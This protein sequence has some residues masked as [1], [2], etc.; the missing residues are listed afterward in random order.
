MRKL[1]DAATALVAF[2][3]ALLALA[4]LGGLVYLIV[5]KGGPAISWGF[6]TEQIRLVGAAGGI[7]WN[8]IGTLILLLTAFLASAPIAIALALMERVWLNGD[9]S[10]R[11]LTTGLYAINGVPSIVFGI[12][13][14]IVLVQWCGWGKSWLAGGLI[15]A[16]VILPTVTVALVERL[17][18]IPMKYVE[19]AA[20]WGSP[21]LRSSGRCSSLNPGVA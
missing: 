10:R 14:F 8:L 18:A 4:L 5:Q 9:T 16:M 2:A 21:A 1:L 20:G 13:G 15:L 17:K 3:C 12:F 6:F 7:F 19:A 11:I